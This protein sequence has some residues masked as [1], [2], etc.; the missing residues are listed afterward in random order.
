M[1]DMLHL[2]LALYLILAAAASAIVVVDGDEEVPEVP[3]R[4]H[5]LAQAVGAFRR[6]KRRADRAANCHEE[7][8]RKRKRYDYERAYLCIQQDYLGPE[9]QYGSQF[10]SIFRVSRGIV[11]RL[12]Q[13]LGNA[14]PFFTRRIQIGGD[15]GIYPEAKVLM[16]LQTMA[17]GCAPQAFMAYY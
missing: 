9:P 7:P 13:V 3:Q 16:A 2:Y 6:I 14:D 4:I 1:E 11:E 12:I 8:P 15:L 17:F 10:E 5:Q